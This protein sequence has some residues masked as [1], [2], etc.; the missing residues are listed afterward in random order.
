MRNKSTW[1][2]VILIFSWMI[3]CVIVLYFAG[4]FLLRQETNEINLQLRTRI[5]DLISF[6]AAQILAIIYTKITGR[7][8][9]KEKEKKDELPK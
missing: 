7:F 2:V 6:I 1:E 8:P 4:M 5:I 3:A 9:E